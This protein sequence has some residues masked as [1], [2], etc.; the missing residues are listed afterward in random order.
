MTLWQYFFS[1]K[2][3]LKETI[4]LLIEYRPIFPKTCEL[5]NFC[6]VILF[7]VKNKVLIFGAKIKVA[8]NFESFK[9]KSLFL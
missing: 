6:T 2:T 9:N 5:N 1:D 4:E 8:H 7:P 3:G